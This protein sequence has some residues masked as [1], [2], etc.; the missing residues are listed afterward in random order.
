MDNILVS[1]KSF[2]DVSILSF[3]PDGV[4]GWLHNY[5]LYIESEHPDLVN[6]LEKFLDCGFYS[7]KDFGCHDALKSKPKQSITP[8]Q[9]SLF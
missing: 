1:D 3:I 4:I 7:A 8:T 5:H 9:L 2:H 6:R